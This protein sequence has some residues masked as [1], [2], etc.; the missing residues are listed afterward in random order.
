[1][2]FNKLDIFDFDGTLFQSPEDSPKNREKYERGTGIPWLIDKD[3]SRKLSNEHG[4]HIGM[5]RGWWGRPETLEPPLVPDPAPKEWFNKDVCDQFLASKNNPESLT[6]I[7]TGRFT[8]LKWH[9]FRI[10]H[11]GGLVE[12]DVETDKQG[13]KW[14]KPTDPNV[15]YYFLGMDPNVSFKTKSPKPS[16][17]F[18]WKVWILEHLMD[19][20]KSIKTVEIWED[21][22]GTETSTSRSSK[23]FTAHSP[24]P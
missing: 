6:L 12:M 8:G 14:H 19:F 5:R 13:K 16:E 22:S 11:D 10:L 21:R 23:H 2:D 1:M 3:L 15:G 7:M 18:P 4:R 20:F 9:V 17:T 24:R